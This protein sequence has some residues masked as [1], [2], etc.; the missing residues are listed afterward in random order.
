MNRVLARKSEGKKQ[1]G[2]PRG[3]LENR[4]KMGLNNGTE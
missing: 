2:I 1:F 4:V 3:G